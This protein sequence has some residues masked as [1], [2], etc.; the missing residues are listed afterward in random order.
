MCPISLLTGGVPTSAYSCLCYFIIGLPNF[1]VDG[2]CTFFCLLI[3]LFHNLSYDP[4]SVLT[5]G[6]NISAFSWHCYIIIGMP[7]FSVNGRGAFFCLLIPVFHHLSYG[8]LFSVKGRGNHFCLLLPLLLPLL[9]HYGFAQFHCFWEGYLFLP[10]C[11]PFSS[12]EP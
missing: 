1:I 10:T 7:N 6:V 4:R 5:G 2:S 9:F 12:F 3:P 11:S 8:P